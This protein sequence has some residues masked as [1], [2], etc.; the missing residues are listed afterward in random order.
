MNVCRP[1][2]EE[3]Q[4]RVGSPYYGSLMFIYPVEVEQELIRE[5]INNNNYVSSKCPIS[6]AVEVEGTIRRSIAVAPFVGW[7]HTHDKDNVIYS[8][9]GHIPKIFHVKAQSELDAV[10]L[11]MKSLNQIRK[12]KE[13]TTSD[14]IDKSS[15]KSSDKSPIWCNEE[16]KEQI[17]EANLFYERRFAMLNSV[18]K[19]NEGNTSRSGIIMMGILIQ[20]RKQEIEKLENRLQ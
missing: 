5:V 10:E 9:D 13:I 1:V 11:W 16:I 8:I 4:I 2:L 17:R 7:K 15:D 3:I 18:L 6:F 19:S 12:E 14:Q 20:E